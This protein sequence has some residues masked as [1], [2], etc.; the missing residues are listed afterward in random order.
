MQ[1]EE[2][3]EILKASVNGL[4]ISFLP[5]ILLPILGGLGFENTTFGDSDFAVVGILISEIA[6]L[7]GNVF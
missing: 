6:K 7:L 5:A 2:D 3:E 1:L 4:L